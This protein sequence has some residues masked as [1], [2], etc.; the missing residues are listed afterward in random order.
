MLAVM[1]TTLSRYK[2]KRLGAE[3]LRNSLRLHHDAVLLYSSK[4]YP[5]AFHI[6]VLSLE[7]LAKAAWV[8]H[9]Y[10]SSITNEGAAP[11]SEEQSWL[12]LLYSHTKK[13]HAFIAQD[14][15]EYSPR[16]IAL[17]KSGALERKK[18]Q[19]VYVGLARMGTSIAVG[20]RLSTP[21][22]ITSTDARQMISLVND[23]FLRAHKTAKD[24]D[25]YF[26][27]EEMDA[28]IN[29]RDHKVVF[30]WPHRSGLRSRLR[31]QKV[32]VQRA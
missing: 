4:S 31:F 20:G 2:F 15:F 7:E 25:Q 10:Y 17:I 32:N 8:G 5:S 26:G 13:Q 18:Q 6:S 3:A 19:A 22:R 27:I 11:A 28:V 1:R 14:I 24:Y 9:Y 16:L 30:A 12:G 29:P 21:A 23:E